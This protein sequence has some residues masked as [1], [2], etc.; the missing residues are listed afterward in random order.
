[1][2]H[3][4]ES[5][6]AAPQKQIPKKKSHAPF[7]TRIPVKFLQNYCK[8]RMP[9]RLGS[10]EHHC[11]ASISFS[12]AKWLLQEPPEAQNHEISYDPMSIGR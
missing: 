3:Q 6:L 2:I 9:S 8:T 12:E 7:G 1:M 5:Q 10:D 11:D 4:N